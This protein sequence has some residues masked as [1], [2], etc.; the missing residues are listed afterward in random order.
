MSKI[1]KYSNYATIETDISLIIGPRF[2]YSVKALTEKSHLR[3]CRPSPSMLYDF[4]SL[5]QCVWPLPHLEYFSFCC[6]IG[7]PVQ[8]T[9]SLSGNLEINKMMIMNSH[10]VCEQSCVVHVQ[11][12]YC[13]FLYL[14]VDARQE[15]SSPQHSWMQRT[16]NIVRRL[17]GSIAFNT[18]TI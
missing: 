7:K 9:S 1:E 5:R 15:N 10:R 2:V 4:A 17:H 18:T 16:R 13:Y 14:Q 3:H 12:C 11:H 6:F 8:R